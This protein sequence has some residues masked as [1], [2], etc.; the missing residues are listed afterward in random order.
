MQSAIDTH[1]LEKLYE[2]HQ[3]VH[4]LN[5]WLLNYPIK[6][7]RPVPADWYGACV[8][9]GVLESYKCIE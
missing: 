7:F 6:P 1:D 4:D 3:I 5:Y 9:F 8:Y 2:F